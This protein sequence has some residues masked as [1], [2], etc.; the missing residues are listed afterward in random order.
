MAGECAPRT[1]TAILS[2]STYVGSRQLDP[3]RSWT[4]R[5][6]DRLR[7]K[8]PLAQTP[9]ASRF[10][11]PSKYTLSSTLSRKNCE[12][13][14]NDKSYQASSF[15]DLE[16]SSSDH[17]LFLPIMEAGLSSISVHVQSW[18]ALQRDLNLDTHPPAC[19]PSP[20]TAPSS[21]GRLNTNPRTEWSS[22]CSVHSSFITAPPPSHPPLPTFLYDEVFLISDYHKIDGLGLPPRPGYSAFSYEVYTGL[23]PKNEKTY[24]VKDALRDSPRFRNMHEKWSFLRDC[25]ASGLGERTK[26]EPWASDAEK[27]EVEME[28][29]KFARLQ[30]PVSGEET[31]EE[32]SRSSVLHNLQ[33]ALWEKERAFG[34]EASTTT[35]LKPTRSRPKVEESD[36]ALKVYANDLTRGFGSATR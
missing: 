26:V 36:Q 32:V 4:T 15:F 18:G 9:I 5:E 10:L 28:A 7:S 6:S 12:L 35:Q 30:R 2:L 23:R 8:K 31:G 3:L 29:A 17:A 1:A 34:R 16:R 20:V 22:L 33:Q 21:P 24:T 13:S 19:P 27:N 11:L 25:L 14:W